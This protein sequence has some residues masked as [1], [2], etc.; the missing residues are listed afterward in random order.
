MTLINQLESLIQKIK[1][2]KI[3][4]IYLLGLNLQDGKIIKIKIYN[5]IYQH[6]LRIYEFLYNFGSSECLNLYCEDDIWQKYDPGFSGFT[7]G[8]ELFLEKNYWN[9]RYGYGCKKRFNDDIYFQSFIIDQNKNIIDYEIYKY[10]SFDKYKLPINKLKTDLIEVQEKNINNYCYC[11]KISKHT[12]H[13]LQINIK[14][15]LNNSNKLIF[16]NLIDRNLYA[17]NYGQSENYEKLYILHKNKKSVL[18]II[19]TIKKINDL[20]LLKSA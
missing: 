18:E 13:E 10:I 17:V 11:P 2:D 12:I 5:K 15:S 9:Y 14:N 19:N 16:D 8:L 4:N 6:H 1:C 7:V 3:N 20:D